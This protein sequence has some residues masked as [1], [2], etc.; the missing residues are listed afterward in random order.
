MDEHWITYVVEGCGWPDTPVVFIYEP[1][2]PK[3][4]CLWPVIIV[5]NVVRSSRVTGDDRSRCP[6]L[7]PPYFSRMERFCFLPSLSRLSSLSRAHS[8]RRLVFFFRLSCRCF[9]HFPGII[10]LS[11]WVCIGSCP[12]WFSLLWRKKEKKEKEKRVL[13]FRVWSV[14]GYLICK[15]LEQV[16]WFRKLRMIFFSKFSRWDGGIIE[17]WF[18]SL[19]LV[20]LQ[21]LWSFFVWP[22]IC[23]LGF[24]FC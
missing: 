5:Y 14:S 16:A 2:N 19:L 12:W 21:G 1:Q 3:G 11:H 18:L 17:K 8:F 24:Q 15:N 22:E 9:F 20:F 23:K 13:K 4:D 10:S 7:S 6:P